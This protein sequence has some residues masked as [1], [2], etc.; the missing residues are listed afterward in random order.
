[1]VTC[2][3]VQALPAGLQPIARQ[4]GIQIN[5]QQKELRTLSRKDQSD[6]SSAKKDPKIL[7]EATVKQRFAEMASRVQ[8]QGATVAMR[9]KQIRND[10]S[11][12]GRKERIEERRQRPRGR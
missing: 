9:G 2:S 12:A 7:D 6:A 4:L 8:D 11:S 3:C 10:K 1:M 5:K